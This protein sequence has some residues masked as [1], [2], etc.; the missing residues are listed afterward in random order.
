MR[1]TRRSFMK[2]LAS[3]ALLPSL[4]WARLDKLEAPAV[5]VEPVVEEPIEMDAAE[6]WFRSINK[7]KP[8]MLRM[9]PYR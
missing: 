8:E 5:E 2:G 3:L 6:R 7:N 4:A 1:M 9:Y